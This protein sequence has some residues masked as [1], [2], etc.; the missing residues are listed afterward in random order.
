[1]SLGVEA[2]GWGRNWVE[3]PEL[4]WARGQRVRLGHEKGTDG[5]RKD[6]VQ[7]LVV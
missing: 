7:G 1:M 6:R 3:R 5:G 4:E 2:G